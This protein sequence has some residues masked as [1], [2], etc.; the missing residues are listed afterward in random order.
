[1]VKKNFLYVDV[2]KLYYPSI[3][4]NETNVFYKMTNLNVNRLS[5][6]IS[7]LLNLAIATK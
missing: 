6:F 4:S 7:K 5:I 2:K 1:L 3:K